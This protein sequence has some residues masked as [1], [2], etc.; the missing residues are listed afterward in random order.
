MNKQDEK[1]NIWLAAIITAAL[2]VWLI[3]SMGCADYRL[4]KRLEEP[5][6]WPGWIVEPNAP[7]YGPH[8]RQIQLRNAYSD[9]WQDRGEAI[10]HE[11]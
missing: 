10:T 11:P 9:G 2:M 4:N 5:G 7:L 6:H 1:R 3:M 8:D